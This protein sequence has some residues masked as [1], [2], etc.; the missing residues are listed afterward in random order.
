MLST[1]LQIHRDTY[2]L[3]SMLIDLHPLFPR[4]HR[5]T[6]GQKMVSAALELFECIHLANTD[7]AARQRHLAA[8]ITK[9]E[10]L[11]VMVRICAEKGCISVRRQAEIALLMNKIGRQATAWKNASARPS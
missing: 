3:A 6:I 2:R 11:Q 4:I 8:F 7:K 9:A 1:E 10:L 5:F